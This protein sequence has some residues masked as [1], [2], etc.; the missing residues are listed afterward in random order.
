MTERGISRRCKTEKRPHK[1]GVPGCSN[2][3]RDMFNVAAS[4]VGALKVAENDLDMGPC[5]MALSGQRRI[6]TTMYSRAI[7]G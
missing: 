5:V 1:D 3:D 6:S 7:S 4:V 2:D